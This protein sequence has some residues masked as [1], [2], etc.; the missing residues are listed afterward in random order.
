MDKRMIYLNHG[1]LFITCHQV[2]G[3]LPQQHYNGLLETF[4]EET[5]WP[6]SFSASLDGRATQLLL[7]AALKY[8]N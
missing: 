7:D 1:A 4:C 5:K 3:K 6:T 2:P 8:S